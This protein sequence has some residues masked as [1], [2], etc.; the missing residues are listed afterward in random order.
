MKYVALVVIALLVACSPAGSGSQYAYAFDGCAAGGRL[1]PNDDTLA[2]ALDT[3]A[4]QHN[5]CATE[6]DCVISEVENKCVAMLSCDGPPAVNRDQKGA[7]EAAFNAE[8][9][10]YCERPTCTT[11]AA[12][13]PGPRR[14]VLVC[15][16]G[17]CLRAFRPL[18]AGFPDA[19]TFIPFDA[20][21]PD[22]GSRDAGTPDAG[23]D[24][25]T[26]DAGF[27]AGM[28]AGE[29]DG[30]ADAGDGGP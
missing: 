19:G 16:E 6:S 15:F 24:A 4:R 27:D 20:G 7:F 5:G 1:C 13:A 21:T 10:D 25:G 22:A 18:D 2:C 9:D 17:Q 3:I 11:R 29:L 12:C 8:F 23:V 30:G 26:F 28:D 14:N